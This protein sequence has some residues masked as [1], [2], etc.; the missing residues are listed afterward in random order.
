MDVYGIIWGEKGHQSQYLQ[1][2]LRMFFSIVQNVAKLW[3]NLILINVASRKH[4]ETNY[5]KLKRAH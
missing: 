4:Q 3:G 2:D 1:V 5:L